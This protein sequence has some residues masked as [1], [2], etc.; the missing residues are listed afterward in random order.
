MKKILA[1]LLIAPVFMSC[2]SSDTEEPL[3]IPATAKQ[4]LDVPYGDDAQQTMDVY[5]PANRVVNRTKVIVL[6]HGGGWK[7][8]DKA[9]LSFLVPTL[10]NALPDYAVVNV[11]Y[12]L[13]S[14][15]SLGNPKQLQDIQSI[16]NYLNQHKDEYGTS[17]Q[18]A[19]VGVSAGAHLSML[20]AYRYNPGRWVKAVA[21]LVGP[22]DF[23]DPNYEGNSLFKTGL[24]Y[25]VGDYPD[26]K[27]NP[28]AFDQVTPVNYI[29]LLSPPTF[30]VYADNDQ[31][32]P[33]T[34]GGIVHQRLN[35]NL[36]YNEFYQYPNMD[37]ANWSVEQLNDVMAKLITFIQN[38][39]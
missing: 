16:F 4:M 3:Q 18:Y 36:V 7:E 25:F 26:Y 1:F 33:N 10:M 6:V 39:F 15:E 2:A 23:S 35:Q 29:N 14:E 24:R 22:A 13:G 38:K 27:S 30:L 8:G 5:L 19:M 31:L 32:V 34:Q 11:N 9:E 37:H 17:R 20:Y 28:A 12:R 21:S